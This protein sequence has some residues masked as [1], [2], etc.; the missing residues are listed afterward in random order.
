MPPSPPDPRHII[1]QDA[2]TVSP[3][4]LGRELATPKR[5]FAALLVD[6]LLAAI[7]GAL[8]GLLL[9]FAAALLFFRYATRRVEGGF[10]RRW[11]RL[12]MAFVGALLVFVTGVAI[13]DDEEDGTTRAGLSSRIAVQGDTAEVREAL[14]EVDA[15]LKA[16]GLNVD[17]TYF[18]QEWLPADVREMMAYADDDEDAPLDDEARTAAAALLRRYADALAAAD[19]TALDTL[20]DAAARVAAGPQM[21][22][23][24]QRLERREARIEAL[25]DEAEVLA[26]RAENPGFIRM[27]KATAADFG[28]TL[29]WMGLYFIVFL[30]YWDGRTPGKHLLG[31]RAVRLDGKPITL[32]NAFE[33]FGGYA[34]GLAT[35]LLGF[36]QVYWD[37]NRQA[38]HDKI[39]GTVV[40]RIRKQ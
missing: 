32:W 15:E 20:Q 29:G 31:L 22:R 8:G 16:A 2:F 27:V 23:L 21:A 30:P 14:K 6:L 37:P 10:V 9:G 24:E 28:L 36:A 34:A 7:L 25:E 38:I 12:S 26:E 18:K 4:L 40:L 1:T 33:R 17:G 11:A 39:A 5:R 13:M 3:D 19:S 35:G